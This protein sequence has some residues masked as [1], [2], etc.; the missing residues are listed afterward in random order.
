MVFA[1]WRPIDENPWMQV[2]LHAA[3]QH[4][5]RLPKPGPEDP[6]PFAFADPARV[7]RV[8]TEAGWAPPT[9]TRLDIMLDIAAGGG[10]DGAV[11]QAMQIGAASRALRE[12]PEDVQPAAI[13]AIRDALAPYAHGAHVRLGGAIWLVEAHPA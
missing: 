12:A 6:G 10:L 3:Y 11:D 9:L 4:V 5:P 1:C 13:A 7:T 8:L 2:P